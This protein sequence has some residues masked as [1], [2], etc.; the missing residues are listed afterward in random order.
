MGNTV[1]IG[2]GAAGMMAAIAAARGG[3]KVTLLEGNDRL[4]KKILSTGNGKCN[5][6]N[7]RL[8]IEDYYTGCPDL[9]EKLLG[10]FGTADTISFFQGI[11]LMVKS[12]NGYLYPACEQAA[13][14]LDV[15]RYEVR[16]AGV[17]VATDFKAESIRL[18]RRAR[19]FNVQGREGGRSFDRVILA[20][21]GKAVPKTGSDGSGYRLAEGLGHSLVPTVPAL[22]QLRCRE[23]C[24]KAVAGVR[25]DA[26]LSVCWQ[27]K[28]ISRERGELQL[29]EY[30][31]SGIP[32]FQLSR[33]VNYILL[34]K[35]PGEAGRGGEG[36]AS[37]RHPDNATDQTAAGGCA[38]ARRGEKR[39]Q[40]NKPKEPG[41]EVEVVIDFLP[42]YTDSDFA[43]MCA[44]RRLLQ[45]QRTVE[46]FFTGMLHKKLMTLFIKLAGLKATESVG[47]A[48]E[49]KLAKVFALCR[50]W[51][52]HV[53]GSNPYD[54]AQVCAG[55][56][57]LDEVTEE[58]ESR[59]VPGLYFAGELLDVDGRC[60]GYN[61]QWA[62]CSG[63]IA[64]CG[65][66]GCREKRISRI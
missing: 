18:G 37:L 36:D 9:L 4:G 19:Q 31:I 22:V 49:R 39:R 23:D 52:V 65:A 24:L 2:G 50:H 41:R 61:L 30:G 43:A 25:A 21:G 5:L 16:A 10:Q 38:S 6:G 46:E 59:L 56:V 13:A 42:D 28:C 64:G 17:E 1:G 32:V 34:G 40:G 27:G 60:G 57:P 66:A 3:A 45:G 63:F 20:C 48:D 7:E 51:S 35:N 11:G 33:T 53:V 47:E 54:S 12:R 15:L 55:G 26:E 29:T 58:L 8:G 62:W 44:G 14:V